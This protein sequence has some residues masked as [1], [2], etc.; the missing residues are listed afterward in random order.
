MIFLFAKSFQLHHHRCKRAPLFEPFLAFFLFFGLSS[1]ALFLPICD[2][3]AKMAY[4][5][6]E[7]GS[8]SDLQ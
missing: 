7:L 2:C 5:I 1:K 8:K 6:G 3:L 4:P